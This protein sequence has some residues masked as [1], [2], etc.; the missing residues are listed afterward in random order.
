ME[1][2]AV[3]FGMQTLPKI[4]S[5]CFHNPMSVLVNFQKQGSYILRSLLYIN[6]N[7]IEILI[8]SFGENKKFIK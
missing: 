8:V 2:E 7:S 6:N 3:N 1:T 4:T 5:F